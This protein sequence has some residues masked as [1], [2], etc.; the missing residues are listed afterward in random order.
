M[1]ENLSIMIQL[2]SPRGF[3]SYYIECPLAVPFIS[4][5]NISSFIWPYQ[6][7]M[8]IEFLCFSFIILEEIEKL[9]LVFLLLH[10]VCKTA[11]ESSDNCAAKTSYQNWVHSAKNFLTVEY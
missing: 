7:F 10:V 8:H 9:G 5:F 6:A 3:I 1:H 2:S 11:V 4:P